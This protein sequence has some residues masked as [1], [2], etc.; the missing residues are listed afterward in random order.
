MQ[1]PYAIT[2]FVCQNSLDAIVYWWN[3][4]DH[5]RFAK[6]DKLLIL[7][8][9]GGSNS[10]RSRLWKRQLQEKLADRLGI[11]VMVCHYP[12]GAS[13]WNP[14]EHRLF[15]QVS[16]SW[17]GQPLTS[18]DVVLDALRSTTTTTGLSVEATLNE[19]LYEK[20]L[21]VSDQDMSA[22][23]IERHNICSDW[24]YTIRPRKTG[25]NL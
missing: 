5:P 22:L 20:G 1:S 19:A 9:A 3:D 10:Y 6:E 8:D 14:I 18:Y 7:C 23:L 25:S 13:K 16:L 15:S 4:E 12:T 11:E 21:T 17:A 24:N 2:V